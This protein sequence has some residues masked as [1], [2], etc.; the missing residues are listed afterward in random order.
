MGCTLQ[1]GWCAAVHEEQS[2]EERF[3]AGFNDRALW[4]ATF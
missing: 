1:A 3:L 4:L 2:K